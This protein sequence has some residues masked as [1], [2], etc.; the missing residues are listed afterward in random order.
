[1]C[2]VHLIKLIFNSDEERNSWLIKQIYNLVSGNYIIQSCRV[3][4][5]LRDTSQKKTTET[6]MHSSRMRTDRCSTGGCM[7]SLPWGDSIWGGF[8]F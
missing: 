4:Q 7:M 6:R 8:P 3:L 2:P 5:I 1:M